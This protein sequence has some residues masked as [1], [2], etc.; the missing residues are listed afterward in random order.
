MPAENTSYPLPNFLVIGAQKAA[1]TWLWVN[2]KKHPDIYMPERKELSYFCFYPLHRREGW[3]G[4]FSKTLLHEYSEIYFSK[5]AGQSAIGEATPAYLWVSDER[6]EWLQRE[7]ALRYDTADVVMRLLGP[8]TKLLVTLRN[9]VER[10]VSALNHHRKLGTVSPDA[11]LFE[12]AHRHGI[13]HMGFYYEHLKKWMR[14]FDESNFKILI[15]EDD[16]TRPDLALRE[17]FCFLGVDP[18]VAINDAGIK[19]HL[20]EPGPSVSEEDRARLREIYRED[21]RNLEVLINRDLSCWGI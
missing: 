12:V 8:K 3:K 14:T 9:P 2:L 13:V 21:V 18:D 10:A 16:L 19:V 7:A 15:V 5:V 4:Q 1:T 17:V 6:P 20:G 11:K